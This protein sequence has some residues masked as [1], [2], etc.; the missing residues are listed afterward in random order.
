MG[1]G[2]I[3]VPVLALG[4]DSSWGRRLEPGECLRHFAADVT[5][6]VVAD[7]GHF[8]PEEQPAA[9]VGHLRA[10]LDRL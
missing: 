9:L 8:V 4:G 1:A 3:T 2:G 7:S 6:D 5:A 10:F